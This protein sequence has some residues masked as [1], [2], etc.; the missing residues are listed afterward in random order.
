MVLILSSF[1]SILKLPCAL[2][3]VELLKFDLI[4]IFKA[5]KVTLEQY[6]FYSLPRKAGG[7]AVWYLM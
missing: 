1:G 7:T 5:S 3:E 6:E 4:Q 2:T